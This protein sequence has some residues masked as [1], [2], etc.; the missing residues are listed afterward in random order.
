MG[1]DMLLD[2][3]IVVLFCIYFWLYEIVMMI[4]VYKDAGGIWHEDRFRPLI[5]GFVNLL[6]NLIMVRFIGIYGILLSTII[7]FSVIS[8]PWIVKNVFEL[9][10]KDEPRTYIVSI[11][12][13]SVYVLLDSVIVYSLISFLSVYGWFTLI[14]K[15]IV[16]VIMSACLLCVFLRR[17]SNYLKA[18]SLFI[19]LIKI[20]FIYNRAAEKK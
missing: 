12:R 3:G 7:S 9:I 10:F 13:Y 19:R 16:C 1:N 17:D 18:R 2:F 6:L 11:L 4:S 5:S 15:A 8:I 20:D 14:I